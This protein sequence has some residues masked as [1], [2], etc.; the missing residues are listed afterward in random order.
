MCLNCLNFYLSITFYMHYNNY[1]FSCFIAIYFVFQSWSGEARVGRRLGGQ[2]HDPGGGRYYETYLQGHQHMAGQCGRCAWRGAQGTG[3]SGPQSVAK[4]SIQRWRA[5]PTLD[6]KEI[7]HHSAPSSLWLVALFYFMVT[8]AVYSLYVFFK[9]MQSILSFCARI[10]TRFF[11]EAK[12]HDVFNDVRKIH[13]YFLLKC[14]CYFL[15]INTKY[16]NCILLWNSFSICK[17]CSANMWTDWM[18]LTWLLRI[19]YNLVSSFFTDTVEKIVHDSELQQWRREMVTPVQE[20]GVGISG[21]PGDDT[22]QSWNFVP[23]RGIS[24]V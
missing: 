21:V 6:H 16:I 13:D 5:A 8:H 17:E 18:F 7:R 19:I 23:E 22:G 24:K 1:K 10:H 20:G 3:C 4:L 15:T 9:I 2:V 12:P 14:N 11:H